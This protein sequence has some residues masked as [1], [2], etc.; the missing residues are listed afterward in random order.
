MDQMQAF[1]YQAPTSI[2]PSCPNKVVVARFDS[3]DTR[4]ALLAWGRAY[5]ANE[6]DLDTA[7]LFAQQW[8]DHEAVPERGLCAGTM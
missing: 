2:N 4:F 7:L 1:F 6:F 5:L 3:M 8:Q